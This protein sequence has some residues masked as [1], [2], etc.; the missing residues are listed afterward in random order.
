M[1]DLA[2]ELLEAEGRVAHLKREI[3][4]G[5]CRQFGH[6]WKQIGGRNAC[7]D[8]QD[9]CG[10]SVPVYECTKCGDSDY[11]DN[12]EAAARIAACAAYLEGAR[13]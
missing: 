9:L 4:N 6:T 5:P 2:A 10:C 11:G 12:D 7:C 1:T 13:Q 8:A 3:A